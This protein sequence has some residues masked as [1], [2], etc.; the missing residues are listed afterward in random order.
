MGLYLDAS[1]LVSLFAADRFSTPASRLLSGSREPL[2]VSAFGSAEFASA[3]ARLVRERLWSEAQARMCFGE[4]DQWLERATTH[5]G[6]EAADIRLATGIIRRLDL[7]L[8]APDAIHLAIAQRL[9]ATLAT[10]DRQLGT[11]AAAFGVAVVGV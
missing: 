2:L 1:A 3:I 4:Y 11:A 7:R 6:I 10:F 9:G 8:R 5:V